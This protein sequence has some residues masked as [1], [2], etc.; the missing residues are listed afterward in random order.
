MITL[1]EAYNICCQAEAEAEQEK[2]KGNASVPNYTAKFKDFTDFS[3]IS[4]DERKIWNER[5]FTQL[6]KL[7]SRLG[8]AYRKNIWARFEYPV[9]GSGNRCDLILTG[10]KGNIPV[11]L[12]VEL[13]SWEKFNASENKTVDAVKDQI[14]NYIILLENR[15]EYCHD[16]NITIKGV[17]VFTQIMSEKIIEEA[18]KNESSSYPHHSIHCEDEDG[19]DCFIEFLKDT[20]DCP[21][22][23]NIDE[24]TKKKFVQFDSGKF[25]YK[26]RDIIKM[27]TQLPELLPKISK[28]LG[29]TNSINE[30]SPDY[31][32]I[33][34]GILSNIVS[35]EKS[36]TIIKGE[37]GSGKTAM[38][39]YIL[40]LHLYRNLDIENKQASCRLVIKSKVLRNVLT[41][42][43]NDCFGNKLG[44]S[45]ITEDQYF[46]GK[47]YGQ[48]DLVIIDEAHSL[49]SI[50]I[51][52]R[53]YDNCPQTDGEMKKVLHTI[54][55]KTRHLVCFIDENQSIYP[56]RINLT[57]EDLHKIWKETYVHEG[58]STYEAEIY[59]LKEQYRLDGDYFNYIKKYFEKARHER[60]VL[61]LE[62]KKFDNFKIII[63]DNK[64]DVEGFLKDSSNADANI[65]RK[66]LVNSP[67]SE[68]DK[69]TLFSNE[70]QN[71]KYD[72]DGISNY[73]NVDEIVKYNSLNHYLNGVSCLGFDIDYGVL[74]VQKN[75]NTE[76]EQIFYESN[77]GNNFLMKSLPFYWVILTRIKKG[78]MIFIDRNGAFEKQ[79]TKSS[80]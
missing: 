67:D 57:D 10:M 43:M 19:Q 56:H 47:D 72:N 28:I 39:I 49:S 20:F 76:N 37:A 68:N 12:V 8:E 48:Y 40:L 29:S 77:P 63:T 38:A 35:K 1:Q 74:I 18:K 41:K 71:L 22:M 44:E 61:K 24:E 51:H 79:S 62:P 46:Y 9:P 60:N 16:D 65:T 59:E 25:A 26:E 17:G 78:L 58:N 33:I 73:M 14:N 34:E 4:G 66:I 45:L 75:I 27:L 36:F 13:K 54:F 7:I 11:L 80:S 53:K 6:H 3:A 30:F 5:N 52:N 69:F 70:I 64:D 15:H 31:K 21:S 42:N 23:N 55:D 50:Q 2:I 32:K